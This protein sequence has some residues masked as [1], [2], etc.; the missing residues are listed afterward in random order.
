MIEIFKNYLDRILN[1]I[2]FHICVIVQIGI[3]GN[4]LQVTREH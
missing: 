2:T 3:N 4:L 1:I